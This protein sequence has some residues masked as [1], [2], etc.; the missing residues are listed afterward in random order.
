MNLNLPE[1]YLRFKVVAKTFKKVIE[2]NYTTVKSPSAYADI[3][4]IS[5]PI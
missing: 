5:T 2:A 4:N 3:L 1:K